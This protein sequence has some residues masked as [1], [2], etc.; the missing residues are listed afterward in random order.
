MSMFL[1]SMPQQ[2]IRRSFILITGSRT[3]SNKSYHTHLPHQAVSTPFR[4]TP[5]ASPRLG[6][7]RVVSRRPTSSSQALGDRGDWTVCFVLVDWCRCGANACKSGVCNRNKKAFLLKQLVFH[8]IK[9]QPIRV[10]D[11]SRQTAIYQKSKKKG[12]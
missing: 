1:I 6:P 9:N 8:I 7:L 5:K 4:E 10:A 2:I 3:S 12:N 11:S